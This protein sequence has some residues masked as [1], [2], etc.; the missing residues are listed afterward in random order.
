MV[1]EAVKLSGITTAITSLQPNLRTQM[2]VLS[3][4]VS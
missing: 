1:L 4:T 2:P 3:Q